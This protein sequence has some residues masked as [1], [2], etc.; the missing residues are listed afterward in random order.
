MR[1]RRMAAL[2]SKYKFRALPCHGT[3]KGNC[4]ER[5]GIGRNQTT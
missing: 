2:D 3:A 5:E 1:I 4:K